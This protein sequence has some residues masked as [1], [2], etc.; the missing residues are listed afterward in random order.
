MYRKE[1]FLSILNPLF[2][3]LNTFIFAFFAAVLA[4][5]PV[6][7]IMTSENYTA[8]KVIGKFQYLGSICIFMGIV[9][10]LLG[11]WYYIIDAK[12][13]PLPGDQNRIITKGLY[14]YVRNP[15]YISWL[16][17]IFGEVL[18]FWSKGLV[19]YLFFWVVFFQF[20]I[21]FFEEPGLRRKFGESYVQ[22]CR[23]VRRWIPRMTAYQE[24]YSEPQ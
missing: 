24:N 9:G 17:I 5:A 12:G 2:N 8:I 10:Y 18:V 21:I 16:L 19:Y 4:F 1:T 6:Y 11:F 23:S 14:R 7:E 13:S 15:M 22:Y 20:R 3:I